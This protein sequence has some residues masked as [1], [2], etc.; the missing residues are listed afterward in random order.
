MMAI[1]S[2]GTNIGCLELNLNQAIHHITCHQKISLIKKSSNIRTKAWGNENQDDFLNTAILIDTDLSVDD[3]LNL[4]L[5]IE[6]EMGRI[7]NIKWEPRIIDIDII[8][9][10]NLIINDPH[11]QVP[12]PLMQERNFVLSCINEIAPEVIHPVLNKTINELY[13]IL[14]RG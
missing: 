14:N 8:L 13:Q 2:L 10:D 11:L 3:L 1:L 6:T 12:H 9:Y 5:S 7:R 4:V